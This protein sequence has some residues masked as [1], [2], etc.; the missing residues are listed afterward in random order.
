MKYQNIL[1]VRKA[2]H[3]GAHALARQIKPWL[4]AH[5]C[6]TTTL[7]A[8]N[9]ED[10]TYNENFDCAIVLG[11]DGT[12]LG[13]ARKLAARNIP[14]LGIN[15]G[16]VGFLTD[17]QPATWESTLSQCLLG[18]LPTRPCLALQWHLVRDGEEILS[19][20]A[21]NDVVVS[22]GSLARLV[23]FNIYANDQSVGYLRSDGL[24][25]ATPVGSSGYNVSAGGPLLYSDMNAIALTPICP[26]M[27]TISHMV[28]P[29][30]IQFRIHIE[31]GSTDCYLTI[32]GQEGALLHTGDHI[33]VTGLPGGILFLGTGHSYF[34]RLRN[35][36]S[37]LKQQP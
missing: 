31:P 11:G 1:L 36:T 21:T 18:T 2:A 15:F 27:N 12:M 29:G 3:K 19:G 22:R 16:R 37:V 32:D 17:A 23:C 26:F 30:D 14:L 8:G 5:G 28:F 6:T 33:N 34:D 35:R 24:I 4:E 9:N 25:L 7:E 20:H 13:V 10:P